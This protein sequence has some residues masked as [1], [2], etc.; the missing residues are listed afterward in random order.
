LKIYLG[1]PVNN[2]RKIYRTRVNNIYIFANIPQ[3]VL[4][5]IVMFKQQ[6]W[7]QNGTKLL[8]R[9]YF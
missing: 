8:R 7:T 2:R 4:M 9:L 5:P 1:I 3:L 6:F